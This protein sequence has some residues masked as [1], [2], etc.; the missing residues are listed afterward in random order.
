MSKRKYTHIKLF[1]KEILEMK[2]AGKT[3]REIAEALG[4]DK[5]QIKDFLRQKRR[6]AQ[7]IAEGIIVNPQG[8]PNKYKS[9]NIVVEQAYEIRRLKMENELLRD[10]LSFSGNE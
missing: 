7:K 6:K 4:L 8:R 5:D 2:E 10:F 3:K 9:Q 1:E